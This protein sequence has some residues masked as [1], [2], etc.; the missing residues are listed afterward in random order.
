M[1]DGQS[2]EPMTES[3][4][5]EIARENLFSART[6]RSDKAG[7]VWAR[8]E[9]SLVWD[10]NGIEYVDFNAGQMASALGHRPPKIV[11]AVKAAADTMI[12]AANGFFNI[13]ELRLA[14]KLASILPPP[15]KR[16]KFL[17]SGSDANEMSMNIARRFTH[18]GEVASP[19]V[20]FLGYSD[21]VRALTYADARF[22]KGYG[23]FPPGG[24]AILAP[25]CYRCPLGLSYPSCEIK[26]LDT[27]FELIDAQTDTGLAA[28]ITEPL[29]SAGGVIAPPKGWLTKLKR[30]CRERGAL[31]ILDEAQS[32][33]GKL[34]TMWGF[35]AEED[36][37]PDLLSMSKHFGGGVAV[38]AVAT[39]DE[40]ADRM[41]ANNFLYTHSHAADP[42]PCAAGLASL[43]MIVDGDLP[44]EATKLGKIW[45]S[46][47][48]ELASSH[49]II[50]DIRGHGLLQGVELVRDRDSKAAAFDAGPFVQKH[51]IAHGLLFSVRRAGSV[52]RFVTP[53]S[54]SRA[55]F[56]K[57]AEVLDD[58]LTSFERR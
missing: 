39:T 44:A 33:L 15:L 2:A 51:C 12:H 55:Q 16:S 57:A 3:D 47:L 8:G 54:T 46:H 49:E 5:L 50:G 25:Y 22:R 37:V 56:D 7:P 13:Y 29:M 4:Y 11:D 14:K 45:R 36:G 34:G 38:S 40:I 31:L 48:D 19:H 53:W 35:Q 43:E 17:E 24:R 20:S 27:S 10:V 30:M 52:L 32:G 26:C 9:G 28:V 21:S 18:G 58:A 6:D 42:L 1:S 41:E 23:P